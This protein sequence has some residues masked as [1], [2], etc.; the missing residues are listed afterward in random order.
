MKL[1]TVKRF[2]ERYTLKHPNS[3][4][5]YLSQQPDSNKTKTA[6]ILF[7]IDNSKNEKDIKN[8][9]SEIENI[10]KEKINEKGSLPD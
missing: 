7:L 6:I 10:L 3:T 8:H 9:I 4:I 1:R 2:L 5:G